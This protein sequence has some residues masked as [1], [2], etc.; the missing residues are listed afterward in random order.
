MN[1]FID[2]F[3]F[4]SKTQKSVQLMAGELC[5][6]NTS[7]DT[8][9]TINFTAHHHTRDG[10]YRVKASALARV[11]ICL[12]NT[13]WVSLHWRWLVDCIL[14][15]QPHHMEYTTTTKAKKCEFSREKPHLQQVSMSWHCTNDYTYPIVRLIY[16]QMAIDSRYT[17]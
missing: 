9:I 15:G 12:C 1:V 8:L 14:G 17:I 13:N 7:D 2:C 6:N 16:R 3:F 11:L 10:A 5:V 4:I